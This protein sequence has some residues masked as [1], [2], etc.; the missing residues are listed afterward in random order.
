[1][2]EILG[3]S[4]NE[5]GEARKSTCVLVVCLCCTP[6]APCWPC[7]DSLCRPFKKN[8]FLTCQTELI[9]TFSQLLC[10]AVL[11]WCIENIC[12]VWQTFL[13]AINGPSICAHNLFTRLLAH[14]SPPLSASWPDMATLPKDRLYVSGLPSATK[15]AD[16]VALFSKISQGFVCQE[17]NTFR[18]GFTSSQPG[19][20]QR[21][22]RGNV[23]SWPLPGTTSP[24]LSEQHFS[25][26]PKEMGP[27]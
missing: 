6:H 25:G 17:W 20:W 22:P 19:N 18:I 1:M 3:S 4:R 14:S 26:P 24:P 21:P 8:F 11:L 12:V 9:R 5:N 15:E 13:D 16:V 2:L 23:L 7:Q 27:F 10:L